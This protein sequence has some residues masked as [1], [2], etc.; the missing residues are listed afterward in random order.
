MN[1]ERFSSIFYDFTYNIRIYWGKMYKI[2]KNL[3]ITV[4]KED[5]K[6]ILFV[7]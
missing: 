1:I 3:N 2:P 7:S 5:R 4:T 6:K